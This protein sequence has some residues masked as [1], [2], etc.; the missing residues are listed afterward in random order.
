MLPQLFK[1]KDQDSFVAFECGRIS[2]DEHFATYFSDR[3]PVDAHQVRE[4]M[5]ARYAWLPGMKKLCGELR[6]ANVPMGTCS[7][8]PTQWATLV[9]DATGLSHLVPWAFISGE[10]GVR[11]PS[12]QAYAAALSIVGRRPTEVIFVDDSASNVAA[13]SAMGIESI[14]FTGAGALRAALAAK[15]FPWLADAATAKPPTPKL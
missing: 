1:V 12:E 14:Q 11:K 2:E 3:R 15:G 10:Q 13:A 4:Y 9:E 5:R 7:N 6:D 8:Y